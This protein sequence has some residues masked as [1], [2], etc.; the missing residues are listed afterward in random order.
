M[1]LS[2]S[3]RRMCTLAF[4]VL[5]VLPFFCCHCSVGVAVVVAVV[6]VVDAVVVDAA[7]AVTDL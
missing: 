5:P 2:S 3:C 1:R 4:V 7:V 6:V